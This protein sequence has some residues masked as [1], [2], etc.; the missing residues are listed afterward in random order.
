MIIILM[1]TTIMTACQKNEQD[2]IIQVSTPSAETTATTI[3]ITSEISTTIIIDGETF[4]DSKQLINSPW[5]VMSLKIVSYKAARAFLHDDKDELASYLLKPETIDYYID[6]EHSYSE[7]NIYDNLQYMSLI[8]ASIASEINVRLGY[9]V[10]IESQSS[11]MYL[12]VYLTKQGDEWKIE[13]IG[14][15]G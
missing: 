12:D 6:D 11:D 8:N 4:S 15:D 2:D 9:A 10:W 3:E 1:L 14:L 13:N 5:S 7:D